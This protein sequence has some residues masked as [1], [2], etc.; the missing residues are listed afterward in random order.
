VRA[1]LSPYKAPKAIEFIQE[2]PK[3]TNGKILRRILRSR[4]EVSTGA[5]ELGN[6]RF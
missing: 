1:R 4:E 2:L 6:Y 5:N 3:N